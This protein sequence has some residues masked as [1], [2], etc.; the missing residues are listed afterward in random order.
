MA[1][2]TELNTLVIANPDAARATIAAYD[3]LLGG[4][5]TIDGLVFLIGN[6][7]DTNFGSNNPGVTFNQE[8]I[9]INLVNALVQGNTAAAARFDALTGNAATLGD[10]LIALYDAFVPL[11]AQSDAGRAFFSRPEAQAFYQA[12]AAERGVS[13]PDGAG[14]VALAALLKILVA[15]DV[16]VG[17]AVNDLISAIGDGSARLDGSALTPLEQA[18]GNNFDDDD[19]TGA[20]FELTQGLDDVTGTERDDVFNAFAMSTALVPIQTLNDGDGIDGGGGRDIL[21]AQLFAATTAPADLSGIEVVNIL[22]MTTPLLPA[23]QNIVLDASHADAIDTVGVRGQNYDVSVRNVTTRLSTV[24]ISDS[25]DMTGVGIDHI[26]A[27][28]DGTADVLDL[29]LHNARAV[30]FVDTDSSAQSTGYETINIHSSGLLGNELVLYNDA[31][32]VTV[33]GGTDLDLSGI[34]SLEIGVLILLDASG[35]DGDL[36]ARLWNAQDDAPQGSADTFELRGGNGND[37]LELFEAIDA[38]ITV[39]TGAGDDVI[40]F[41]LADNGSLNGA[42]GIDGGDGYDVLAVEVTGG[43]MGPQDLLAAGMGSNIAG[44]ER[45][46]HYAF[47]SMQDD[48][49]VDWTRKGSATE[50]ELAAEYG[51][52]SVAVTGLTNSDTVIVTGNFLFDLSL[53][54]LNGAASLSNEINLVFE[55][56]GGATLGGLGGLITDANTETLRI[57]ANG[58]AGVSFRNA[59]RLES[60]VVITGDAAVALGYMLAYDKAGGTIDGSGASGGL[61]LVLGNAALSASGGSADDYIRTE[62]AWSTTIALDAGGADIVEIAGDQLSASVAIDSFA[63][64]VGGFGPDDRIALPVDSAELGFAYETAGNVSVT[65]NDDAVLV[66]LTAGAANNASAATN[67]VKFTTAVGTTGGITFQQAFDAA[68]GAGAVQNYTGAL[69]LGSVY[70]SSNAQM[71]LLGIVTGGDGV[72]AGDTVGVITTIGMTAEQYA[73]F[74]AD[75]LLFVM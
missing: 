35:F 55:P 11:G 19:F 51:V 22:G 36:T 65:Q 5:P 61:F 69:A 25:L 70:D 3:V 53:A 8:N 64:H 20:S 29:N 39:H 45:I 56:V 63:G 32:T 74:G 40:D 54:S 48:L 10:Q 23:G 72:Q 67:F 17:D 27:A 2:L 68:I 12:V 43:N 44:I 52:R 75:Q 31:P 50:L 62:Q 71:L 9:F 37:R 15:D 41:V 33:S 6:A 47:G 13:G 73:A 66:E 34:F 58:D 21:N 46:R 60:D 16:G 30:F 49:V 57:T 24:N 26:G 7:R 59:D 14:I 18:D 1:T 38:A 42:D 28:T 4:V